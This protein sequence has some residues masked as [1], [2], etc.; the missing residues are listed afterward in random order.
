[1]AKIG[2]NNFRYGILTEAADGTPSY[3]GAKKPAKA[4]SCSVDITNNEAKLFADDGLAESDTSFQSGTA[5]IGIDDEDQTT[6]AE[7]LGHSIV[8]GAMVRNADDVA[9]YVGF[10]RVIVKMVNNVRMYKVEFLYKVKFAEPSQDDNTQGES[11]EFSTPEIEGQVAKLENG[12]WSI[13]KT[14]TT[15]A[16]AIAYLEGLLGG[17]S[18]STTY[19]VTYDVTTNGGTGTVAAVTVPDGTMITVN[20]GSGITPP[21]N[22]HFVGW[23]TTAAATNPDIT[24]TYTV[25][26]NVTLY[27]IYAAN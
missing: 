27:A 10:G 8:N 26:G 11:L 22:K 12:N 3:G 7:M 13:T 6:M 15:K 18:S 2:L 25:T 4:I 14:F 17:G 20:D 9:P 5:T 24:A 23:D 16:E 19:T 1:M 21:S